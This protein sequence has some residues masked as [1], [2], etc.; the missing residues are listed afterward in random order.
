MVKKLKKNRC[1]PEAPNK[2][3]NQEGQAYM[4]ANTRKIYVYFW[5]TLRVCTSRRK[6]KARLQGE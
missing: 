3:R 1:S 4:Q 6:V 2:L 5:L